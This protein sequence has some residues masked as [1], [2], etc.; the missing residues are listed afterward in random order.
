MHKA[1]IAVATLFLVGAVW[2]QKPDTPGSSPNSAKSANPPAMDTHT[3]KGTLVDAS[4]GGNVTQKAPSAAAES[5][6]ADREAGAPLIH[7][8]GGTDENGGQP[9]G[10][11]ATA[12]TREF[13]LRTSDGKI[14]RFD[15]VGNQRAAD[16]ITNQK[17]WSAA[18]SAGK[19]ISAKVVGS[20]NGDTLT[21][22]SVD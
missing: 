3:Y 1:A 11:T 16:A 2:A 8:S 9:K 21:V 12:T 18:A 7:K 5:N 22:F 17:K 6:A 14:L 20:L 10:C 13:G 15:A 19:S 4:C